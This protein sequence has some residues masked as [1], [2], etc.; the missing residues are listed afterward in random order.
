MY[1]KNYLERNYDDNTLLDKKEA[2]AIFLERY[3]KGRKYNY[4]VKPSN[5]EAGKFTIQ[6]VIFLK[7]FLE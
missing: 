1:G 7:I 3:N 2:T 6:N 5:N 4:R